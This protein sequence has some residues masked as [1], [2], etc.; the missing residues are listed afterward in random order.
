MNKNRFLSVIITALLISVFT[1]IVS[2]QQIDINGPAGSQ[3]YG[4]SV[5]PLPNGNMQTTQTSGFGYYRFD[6]LEFGET[7]TVTISA[8]RYSF[9]PATI[10]IDESGEE[11]FFTAQ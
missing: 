3:V 5:V 10:T 7:Y 4:T 8:R 11:L 2:A 6:N 1:I 9:S